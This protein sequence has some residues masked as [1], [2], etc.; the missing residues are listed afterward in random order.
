[1]KQIE[2]DTGTKNTSLNIRT[3]PGFILLL[4]STMYDFFKVSQ[5]S[6]EKR[7]QAYLG[8]GYLRVS[9]I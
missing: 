3:D 9:A 2:D 8:D 4:S 1:M 5:I 7:N 6:Q